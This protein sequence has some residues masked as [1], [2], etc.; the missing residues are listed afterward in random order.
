MVIILVVLATGNIGDPFQKLKDTVLGLK[1][2][3]SNV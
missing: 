2:I 3:G 1:V